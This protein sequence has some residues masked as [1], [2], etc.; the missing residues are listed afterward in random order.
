MPTKRSDS[1]E[2]ETAMRNE[3]VAAEI[4]GRCPICLD[5]LCDPY[6]TECNHRFCGQCIKRALGFK[7]E[8]PACRTQIASHRKLFREQEDT[9]WESQVPSSLRLSIG[10]ASWAFANLPPG[11][12]S[13]IHI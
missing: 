6:R 8:C 13:L 12:L 7:K 1:I 5:A 9:A 11:T 4:A 2:A 10:S 3:L